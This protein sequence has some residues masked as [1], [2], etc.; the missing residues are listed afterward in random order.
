MWS[1]FEVTFGTARYWVDDTT[2][3]RS[4]HMSLDD[5]TLENKGIILIRNFENNS[6]STILLYPIGILS[7]TAVKTSNIA[8]SMAMFVRTH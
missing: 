5:F 4:S 3:K 6:S 8:P 1:D 7:M 2:A